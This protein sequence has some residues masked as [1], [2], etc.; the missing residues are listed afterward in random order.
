[1]SWWIHS[2]KM[3]RE[4]YLLVLI[5]AFKVFFILL[6]SIFTFQLVFNSTSFYV[7]VPLSFCAL[8]FIFKIVIIISLHLFWKYLIFCNFKKLR[9]NYI[10]PLSVLSLIPSHILL[11]PLKLWL[12]FLWLLLLYMCINVQIYK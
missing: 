9:Y 10:S 8:Y 2:F 1:M 3:W 5:F 12:P 11:L 7:L 6:Q 4:P